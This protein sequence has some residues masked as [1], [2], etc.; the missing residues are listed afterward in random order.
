MRLRSQG[1]AACSLLLQLGCGPVTEPSIDP[2]G[3]TAW[4]PASPDF[5]QDCPDE[6][7]LGDGSCS[8]R[9]AQWFERYDTFFA[10]PETQA[11]VQPRADCD[12]LA[13][14]LWD[15]RQLGQGWM[16]PLDWPDVGGPEH[17]GAAL[18]DGVSM[19]WLMDSL[20]ARDLNVFV[21][22]EVERT[23]ASGVPFR[24]L[25]LVLRDRFAGDVPA[26]LLLPEGPGPF[27]GVV[28]LPGHAEDAEFHID[29]RY[30]ARF[31]ERGMALLAVSFR[32]YQ[33]GDTVQGPHP[34]SEAA[35]RFLCQ[36]MNL[37]TMRAYEAA[38]GLRALR[39]HDL[40]S[41]DRVGVLGHSGGSSAAHLLLWRPEIDVQAWV[42]DNRPAHFD[43]DLMDPDD[44]DT[45]TVDCGVHET[46][47]AATELT[48]DVCMLPEEWGRAVERV[49]Y[50]YAPDAVRLDWVDSCATWP[51]EPAEEPGPDD[52]NAADWFLPFFEQRLAAAS[53]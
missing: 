11:A 6:A 10:Q 16:Q 31:P 15:I 2:T 46:L 8:P 12:T 18:W 51:W 39:A 5:V 23:T 25:S 26:V 24:Q 27:P 48:A 20:P 38:L 34:D 14:D 40:V 44:P 22:D 28:V 29:N 4:I 32:A 13:E 37:M 53:P 35:Q 45:V 50:A 33:Q 42:L 30:G 21:L 1:L 17:L 49:P 7:R 43:V 52:P 9:T 36:G 19:G 3:V 41:A 47:D